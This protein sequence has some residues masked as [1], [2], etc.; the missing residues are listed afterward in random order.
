MAHIDSEVNGNN[1]SIS[2]VLGIK[3]Q[4]PNSG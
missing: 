4:I 1:M 2:R 3:K